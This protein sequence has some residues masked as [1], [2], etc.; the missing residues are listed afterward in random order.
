M[1]VEMQMLLPEPDE[2]EFRDEQGITNDI[3]S[4]KAEEW[5]G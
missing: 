5:L 4:D 2:Q 1:S 3:E